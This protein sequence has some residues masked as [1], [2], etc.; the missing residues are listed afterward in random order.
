MYHEINPAEADSHW[1]WLSGTLLLTDL[2]LVCQDGSFVL[3]VLVISS[4]APV[5]TELGRNMAGR[6]S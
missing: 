1:T 5:E 2:S 4:F 6:L 3:D